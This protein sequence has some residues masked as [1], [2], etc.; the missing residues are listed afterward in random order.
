MWLSQGGVSF[1]QQLWAGL[2]M[3]DVT[4]Y[5]FCDQF[6]LRG[7]GSSF[8]QPGTVNENV[9]ENDCMPFCDGTTR[10]RLHADLR[11]LEEM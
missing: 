11:L 1:C 5:R 10:R 8:L 2:V 7:V 9:L 4:L 6:A 3:C